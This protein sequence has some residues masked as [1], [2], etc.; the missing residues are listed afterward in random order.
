MMQS[1]KFEKW[2]FNPNSKVEECQFTRFGRLKIYAKSCHINLLNTVIIYA[3]LKFRLKSQ[4]QP[5][6]N[7]IVF[8]SENFQPRN[9]WNWHKV[10]ELASQKL[11]E[12]DDWINRYPLH[13]I[14]KF[15][16]LFSSLSFSVH[17]VALYI[18]HSQCFY[19]FIL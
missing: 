1:F 19:S 13:H 2:F 5:W 10:V 9:S 6:N 3:I 7:L 8:V 12:V 11:F 18:L 16:F 4:A 14:F 15:T 17:Y